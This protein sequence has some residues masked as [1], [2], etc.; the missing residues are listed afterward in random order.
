MPAITEYKCPSCG[1]PLAFDAETGEVTCASCGNT[2][3]IEALR[4][5]RESD[6][7]ERDFHWGDYKSGLNPEAKLDHTAVYVCQSCG[8]EIEAD[9]N[10]A[11]TTCPYCG[12]NVVLDDRVG[13]GLRPNAVIPFHITKKQLPEV[14]RKFYK[15]KKLLPKDFFSEN[16]VGK[17]QGVYVP[18]WLFDADMRGSV[19]LDATKVR[20]YRQGDYDCTKTSHYLL[21]RDGSMSFSK[22]PVDASTRMDDDLMDSVEPFDYSA[23]TDFDPAYLSGYLADRFDSDPDAELPRAEARMRESAKQQFLS[24][25]PGYQGVTLRSDAGLRLDRASVKY[26]LLPVYLLNCEYRGKQY[27]Y[28]VNGQTGKVVGELPI[29]K[30]KKWAYFGLYFAI[31]FAAGFLVTLLPQLL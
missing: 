1:A 6:G 31:A 8:A 25:A 2:V 19:S 30:G 21:R 9:E 18:F 10:T 29:S 26:A 7:E 13:G 23:L 16:V 11:A 22:L 17:A 4:A 12:N 20:T 14:I 15:K 28:A 5:L 3:S 24:T 27:R